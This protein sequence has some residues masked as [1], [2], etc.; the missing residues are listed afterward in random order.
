MKKIIFYLSIF[1][2]ISVAIYAFIFVY[3]VTFNFQLVMYALTSLFFIIFGLYGLYAEMLWEKFRKM[4]KTE[5]FCVEANYYIQKKGYFGRLL[6]FPFIKIKSS[7]SFV[8]SFL[9]ATTWIII[10]S[11]LIKAVFG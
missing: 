3:E 10:L 6:F 1:I 7:N 2:S 4:G 9:G 11:I 5:N 8:V